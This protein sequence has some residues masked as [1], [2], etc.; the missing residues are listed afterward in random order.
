MTVGCGFGATEW[1][2]FE[3]G[4]LRSWNDWLV[5]REEATEE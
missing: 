2:D 1:L 4:D 5:A 3:V